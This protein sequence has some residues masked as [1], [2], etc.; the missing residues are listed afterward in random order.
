MCSS[1]LSTNRIVITLR[2]IFCFLCIFFSPHSLHGH[3]RTTNIQDRHNI[4][5]ENTNNHGSAR[6]EINVVCDISGANKP[7]KDKTIGKT[8]QNKCGSN[9]AITPILT[10]LFFILFPFCFRSPFWMGTFRHK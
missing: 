6:S 3:S 2:I 5:P 10:A 8:Q 4:N 7:I 1:T 9:D